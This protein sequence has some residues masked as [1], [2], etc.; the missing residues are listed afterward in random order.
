MNRRTPATLLRRYFQLKPISAL[1]LHIYDSISTSYQKYFIRCNSDFIGSKHQVLPNSHPVPRGYV[2]RPDQIKG[3][4]MFFKYIGTFFCPVN[5]SVFFCSH[6]DFDLNDG[7]ENFRN[8]KNLEKLF[9][10]LRNSEGKITV[11]EH[12][13]F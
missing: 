12:K 8:R 5:L 13:S 7:F 10:D 9:S 11:V 4:N 1:I 2:P 3:V 6:S